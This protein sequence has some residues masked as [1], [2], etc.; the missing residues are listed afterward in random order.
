MHRHRL[1]SLSLSVASLV[2]VVSCSDRRAADDDGE[3]VGSSAEEA[4]TLAPGCAKMIKVSF[5]ANYGMEAFDPNREVPNRC[6]RDFDPTTGQV[7][8]IA[9]RDQGWR[10]CGLDGCGHDPPGATHWYYDD[11]SPT[12][13]ADVTDIRRAHDL[14]TANNPNGMGPIKGTVDMARRFDPATGTTHWVVPNLDIVDRWFAE[15]HSNAHDSAGVQMQNNDYVDE[16]LAL[17]QATGNVAIRP[18]LVVISSTGSNENCAA[19]Y[20]Q[21]RY[22]CGKMHSGRTIALTCEGGLRLEYGHCLGD[23]VRAINDCTCSV[24]GGCKR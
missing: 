9:S 7:E 11:T 4:I 12:H 17:V 22:A 6:W 8:N 13:T 23:V 18:Q 10:G 24:R 16:W 3:P 14:R 1:L 5:R 15:T 21:I 2:L 19:A 20:D